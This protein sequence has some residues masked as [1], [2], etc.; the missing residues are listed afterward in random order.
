VLKELNSV[1]L[2]SCEFNS[3]GPLLSL[4]SIYGYNSGYLPVSHSKAKTAKSPILTKQSPVAS[5]NGHKTI[6]QPAEKFQCLSLTFLCC[7]KPRKTFNISGAT[8][9]STGVYVGVP[10]LIL[11][12][13][14][15]KGSI[16]IH[17]SLRPTI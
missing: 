17:A 6:L 3:H 8:L 9:T 16:T 4:K 13:S 14:N 10:V 12:S 15:Q 5:I 11:P 2:S 1:L 7:A